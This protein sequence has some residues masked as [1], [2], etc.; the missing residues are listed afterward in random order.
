V[1]F[2][3]IFLMLIVISLIATIGVLP[4]SAQTPYEAYTY[5]FYRDSVPLPAPYLPDRSVM[6]SDL[7]VGNFKDP[8]D[9]YV[10]ED[11]FIYILDSGNNRIISTDSE[12]NVIR[13][14]TTF[15]NAGKSDTFKNPGGI[16]VTKGKMIYVADT[17]NNRIIVLSNEGELV[18][19]IDNPQSDILPSNFKFSP[20]KLA[21]DKANRIFVVARGIYEG[22]MQ[23]DEKGSFIGYVGTINV[24][25]SF[26]DKIWLRLATDA[27]RERMQ[28]YIPTEFSSVD[29]DDKGFVYSTNID[30][31]SETP[32]KRLNPSGQ[33]VLKRFGYYPVMGDVRF[34]RFGNNSGP[35]KLTDIKVISGGMYT[36]LDSYRGRLFTYNDEGDLLYA[37]GGRGTQ[38]GL[39]NTPVAVEMVGDKLTVLDRG[40]NS[41]VVFS[42]SLFG[43]TVHKA[44]SLHY[45]GNGADAVEAWR[46][47]LRLNS[48]YDFAYLGIGKSLL[49]EKKNKEAMEY[50]KLGTQ[51]DYYT[52]AFKRYR[53]EVMQE[54]FG[55][56]M[57]VMLTL[58]IVFFSLR[59]V[60][61][62]RLRR[63][64]KHET[65]AL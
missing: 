58:V 4:I 24:T 50:F 25:Q 27:Q 60:K 41:I 8:N 20:V 13:I 34:R 64:E 10:T 5:N 45:N 38:L 49:M 2:I 62:W 32:V 23:F 43:V 63:I 61:R 47:V 9:M 35:S 29:I 30:I 15:D 55:T 16:F 40:K 21:V 51:R 44:T 19:I 14:I 56:F 7:G 46:N 59:F 26:T 36:V 54:H 33:D 53:R 57:S 17:D 11:G 22:L 31:N 42:P 28:L 6:G 65:G 48:N 12:W 3:K 39:F 18:E 1:K 37:F 52:V